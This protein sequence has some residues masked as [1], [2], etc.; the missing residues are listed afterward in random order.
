MHIFNQSLGSQLLLPFHPIAACEKITESTN[1]KNLIGNAG[2]M[3][4]DD[5]IGVIIERNI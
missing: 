1:V 5:I 3:H 2:R 4:E